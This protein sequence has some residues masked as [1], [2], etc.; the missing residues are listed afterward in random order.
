VPACAQ[1]G[2]SEA[3]GEG[4]VAHAR[5]CKDGVCTNYAA[6]QCICVCISDGTGSARVCACKLLHACARSV[7]RTHAHT[8]AYMAHCH[9]RCV[10]LRVRAG[11]GVC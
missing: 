7:A 9:M 1:D 4:V 3:L 2:G 6:M 5:A 8:H 11:S 10:V